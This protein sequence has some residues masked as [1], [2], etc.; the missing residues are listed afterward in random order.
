MKYAAFLV[1]LVGARAETL[2]YAINWQ[3]GLSLGEATLT[4][5]RSTWV[6]NGVDTPHWS[7]DLDID[8]SVPGFAVN[9]HYVS[10]A[11][12]DICSAKLDK[13]VRRGSHKSEETLTFDQE[14]HS[15]TRETHPAGIGGKSDV[16]GVSLRPR[17]TRLPAVHAAG[18]GA[19][20]ARSRKGR[21]SW[22]RLTTSDWNSPELSRSR[23]WARWW[24]RT[25]FMPLSRV[26]GAIW[27]WIFSSARMRPG[28]LWPCASRWLW[29]PSAWSWRTERAGLKARGEGFFTPAPPKVASRTILRPCWILAHRLRGNLQQTQNFDPGFYDAVLHRNWATIRITFL[30]TTPRGSIPAW[31]SC[32]KPI[33][34]I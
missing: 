16:S 23:S 5:G 20:P 3:S 13:T 21:S 10:S 8:A 19:R 18:T 33:C 28:H 12:A 7:F 9:D 17:R 25:G 11:G 15:V 31:W 26:R 14:Q 2:H 30:C 4:S 27:A 1:F 32:M 6:V 29:A 24:M 34:T 22:E